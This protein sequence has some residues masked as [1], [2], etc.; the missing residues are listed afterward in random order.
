M[1]YYPQNILRLRVLYTVIQRGC[2]IE[3]DKRSA[4][5]AATDDMPGAPAGTCM[6]DQYSQSGNSQDHS[7]AVGNAM[8]YLFPQMRV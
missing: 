6:S 4:K 1:I 3:N 5:D 8:G 2:G 7:Y